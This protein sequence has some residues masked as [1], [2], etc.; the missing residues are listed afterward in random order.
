MQKRSLIRLMMVVTLATAFILVVAAVRPGNRSRSSERE[1]APGAVQKCSR[2]QT[3]GEFILWE[4]LS[5]TIIA[6]AR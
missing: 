5:R 1:D 3:Q 4:S 6:C 2:N